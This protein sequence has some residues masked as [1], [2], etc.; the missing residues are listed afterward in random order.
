MRNL[1]QIPNLQRNNTKMDTLQPPIKPQ[2]NYFS[3]L[4]KKLQ[5]QITDDNETEKNNQTEQFYK[6]LEYMILNDEQI[7][8]NINGKP[9]MGKSAAGAK[10]GKHILDT[11]KKHGKTTQTFGLQHIAMDQ[12]EK[13]N[14]LRQPNT[15][16]TVIVTDE[17][18]KLERTGQDTTTLQAEQEDFSNLHADRMVHQIDISPREL[19]NPNCDLLLDVN[20]TNKH[21]KTTYCRLYYRTTHAGETHTTLVGH[22]LIYVGDI[23]HT[24]LTKSKKIFYKKVTLEAQHYTE[25]QQKKPN[26]QKIRHLQQQ[27]EQTKKKLKKLEQQD[28]YTAYYLKKRFKLDLI[29]KYKIMRPRLLN[30]AEPILKTIQEYKILAQLPQ[31]LTPKIIHAASK[32]NM[33]QAGLPQS[34]IGEKLTAD[35]AQSVL[36]QYE[37]YHKTL[38]HLEH[39]ENSLT[40]KKITPTMYTLQKTKL[41]QINQ[42]I[43]QSIKNQETEYEN[44]IR[45]NKEYQQTYNEQT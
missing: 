31:Y 29:T 12:N 24:W 25:T 1:Q 40:K 45:L 21:N 34:I 23:L 36:D 10:L 13:I 16:N 17:D 14:K 15:M 38:K 3:K 33:R 26:Q 5:S 30:Y 4:S 28:W 37:N 6:E 44:M 27:L 39:L 20:A 41:E 7:N 11:M 2:E 8:I 32:N 9:R 19:P 43:I 18:N 22:T 35:E 42:I